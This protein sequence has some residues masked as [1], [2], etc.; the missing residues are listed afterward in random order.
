M[1]KHVFYQK[2]GMIAVHI[3]L[4][5]NRKNNFVN[6]TSYI[7]HVTYRFHKNLGAPWKGSENRKKNNTNSKVEL[8]QTNVPNVF[9]PEVIHCKYNT[10]G[11]RLSMQNTLIYLEFPL[12]N[13][14]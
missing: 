13:L 5:M 11:T 2:I 14:I 8:D 12:L 9:F 3:C 7:H 10:Q 1:S 6:K 4:K